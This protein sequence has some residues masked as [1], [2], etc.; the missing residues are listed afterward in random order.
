MRRMTTVV[1]IFARC[2]VDSFNVL[3]KDSDVTVA[4]LYQYS[5]CLPWQCQIGCYNVR[6]LTVMQI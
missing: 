1:S 2:R 6:R 3:A 5:S 4:Q